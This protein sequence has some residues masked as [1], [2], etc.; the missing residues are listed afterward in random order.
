M[1]IISRFPCFY[2]ANIG[3]YIIPNP[4]PDGLC[5]FTQNALGGRG[6]PGTVC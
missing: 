4:V 6:T 3:R 1:Y 5:V 2:N